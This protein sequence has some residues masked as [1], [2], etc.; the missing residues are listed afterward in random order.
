M[1]NENIQTL[2]AKNR[3]V[4]D[5]P[6]T[7]VQ[8]CRDVIHIAVFFDGTG[9]NDE[10]D[11][12]KKKWSNVAR[13]YYSAR[14]AAHGQKTKTQYAIYIA[15][16]GTKFN[17]RAA[18]WIAASSAWIED[19][20]FGSGAGS[21][22][23][24]RMEHAR[25]M[26]N[27]SLK[28]ALIANAKL[29]G[30]E[31]AKY[32]KKSAEKSFEEVNT[33]LSKH[34]LI[35]IIN[36][37]IFGFSRGAALAR[38]FANRFVQACKTEGD[39]LLYQGY[40][41][42]INFIGVFDTVASFGV[43]A[44][45]ARTPF[46]ERELVVP[47][48]VERC[49]HFVAAHELRFSFPVDLIRKGGALPGNWLEKV[50]PGVHS[51][52]GGGYEPVEQNI[53]NNYARIPMRDMLRDAVLHGVRMLSYDE[54]KEKVSENFAA[55]F[56]CKPKTLNSFDAYM[57]SLPSAKGAVED[58][59]KSH[60]MLYYSVNG[61]M[62]RIGVKSAGERSRE[63]NKLKYI[64]GSKGMAFEVW[65]YQSLLK[66]G[67]W[68]RLSEKNSRNLAQYVEIKDWQLAAWNRVALE[69]AINF[70]A[71]YVHDSKV[72]F[73]GNVEPFTYFRPRGVDE[74]G[75]SV[76]AE[77]GNWIRAE[78]GNA[79]SMAA[80]GK[81]KFVDAAEAAASKA[82][83]AAEAAQKKANEA[84][85]FAKRKVVEAAAVA[86]KAY[87]TT[88]RLAKEAAEAARREAQEAAD[89]AKKKADEAEEAMEKANDATTKS[90]RQAVEGTQNRLDELGSD[91]QRIYENGVR[92]AYRKVDEVGNLLK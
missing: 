58:Q 84:S 85:E 3:D 24:R 10:V 22:G 33:A 23:D 25:D 4:S 65:R 61:T 71:S 1:A 55:R 27:E 90:T 44:Q 28:T 26:V 53:D 59:I 19:S 18:E 67:K 78:I 77:G 81:Q 47:K 63:S 31:T 42:R 41:L 48:S 76:W 49:V 7:P 2:L 35:K 83:I 64:F 68:L 66:A 56:E 92:W 69:P 43:P 87:D 39:D 14:L 21:G 16:V 30:S 40:P 86:H 88:A 73:L 60:L 20:M 38:A 80:A 82:K 6:P 74:S 54:L 12:A 45:N 75:I 34:R 57:A 17:G 89:Y 79:I 15:G 46:T 8:D 91:A 9:N 11:Q 5:E 13:L 62:N 52:V 36:L 51:D 50:Y 37:S 32:A 29:F 72:D 70:I